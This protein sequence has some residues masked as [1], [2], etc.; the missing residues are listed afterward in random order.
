MLLSMRFNCCRY[1]RSTAIHAMVDRIVRTPLLHRCPCAWK[2][3][4]MHSDIN[5]LWVIVALPL[6][7]RPEAQL[8][9]LPTLA[10]DQYNTITTKLWTRSDR[11]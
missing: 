5:M 7:W 2:V 10:F 4:R 8:S 6:V 1:H 3:T 11:K 9:A